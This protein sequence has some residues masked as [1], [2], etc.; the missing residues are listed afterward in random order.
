[1]AGWNYSWI[2]QLN[3]EANSWTAPLDVRRIQPSED[4][5]QVTAGR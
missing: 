5:R 1:V 2:A 4:R 3:W